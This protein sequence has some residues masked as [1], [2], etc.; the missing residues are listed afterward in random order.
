MTLLS[1][2]LDTYCEYKK[3]SF[4][5]S[6][7]I[8]DFRFSFLGHSAQDVRFLTSLQHISDAK[9]FFWCFEKLGQKSVCVFLTP[10]LSTN[11][12]FPF[13]E[14]NPSSSFKQITIRTEKFY[15]KIT[16]QPYR[17]SEFQVHYILLSNPLKGYTSFLRN[18]TTCD[19]NTKVYVVKN[20]NVVQVNLSQIDILKLSENDFKPDEVEEKRV[21]TFAWPQ[22]IG[23]VQIQKQHIVLQFP[24]ISDNFDT[25]KHFCKLISLKNVYIGN[26]KILSTS[27]IPIHTISDEFQIK[28]MFHRVY[29]AYLHYSSYHYILN[30]KINPFN[31][32]FI[33]E[34]I[35]YP[36]IEIQLTEHL[37]HSTIIKLLVTANKKVPIL[38]NSLHTQIFIGPHLIFCSKK[39]FGTLTYPTFHYVMSYLFGKLST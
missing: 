17:H 25:A 39:T 7:T 3:N 29:Q 32:I 33:Q 21:Y 1:N 19:I 23:Y 26:Q 20:R 14:K 6:K 10:Y 8:C 36:T 35:K 16:K 31:G 11:Y 22:A 28:D 15:T 4:S 24:T 34:N 13:W 18:N 12:Y 37:Y 27:W 2:I 9:F 30:Q 38:K 5:V